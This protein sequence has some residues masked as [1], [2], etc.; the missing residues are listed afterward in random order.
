MTGLRRICI[1]VFVLSSLIWIRT[2]LAGLTY[3]RHNAAHAIPQSGRPA[4]SYDLPLAVKEPVFEEAPHANGETSGTG[5]N[6]LSTNPGDAQNDDPFGSLFKSIVKSLVD[7]NSSTIERVP[8]SGQKGDKIVVMGRLKNESTE[9][10]E[11][12]L[13]EYVEG[14][15]G[16]DASAD[17]AFFPVG[18]LPYIPSMMP[19]L[20]YTPR[21]IKAKKQTPTS[22]I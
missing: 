20:P 15:T 10:V 7:G 16:F 6:S 8:F 2:R 22:H 19:L 4:F 9:W 12:E 17:G 1:A 3:Q 14:L 13:P 21:K 11:A 18:N 5:T